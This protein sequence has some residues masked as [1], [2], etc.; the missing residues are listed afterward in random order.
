A[1][2]PLLTGAP[3]RG[4]VARPAPLL[5][6]EGLTR[7]Y[8][9]RYALD[10]V[11]FDLDAGDFLIVLG[12]NGAGKTTLLKLLARLARPS[13][14]RVWLG[15]EDWLAAPAA[16]QREIGVLSHASYLYDGLTAR[17]NLRFFA[18]LY[19][20]PDADACARRALATVGLEDA[21]DRR[22]GHLSRGQAQRVAIARAILHDPGILLLDEP[23]AGLDPRAAARLSESLDAVHAAGRTV[24]LTTHD[25]A[26]SPRA[27]TRFLV[28]V[29]GRARS[30][31][32]LPAGDL[33]AIYE[34]AVA[35]EES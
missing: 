26:R 29:E 11:S 24:V 17:E 2:P 12:P 31:G 10:D 18:T 25:L 28:V 34:R 5:R 16:R 21:G 3:A 4:H 20:L 33:A 14:G 32:S 22:V 23:Y 30:E 19:G 1:C 7:L 35:A 13:A 27:A 6:V 9:P 15:G 8:G